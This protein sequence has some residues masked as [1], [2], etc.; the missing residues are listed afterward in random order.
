MNTV[1]S[2]PF[3]SIIIPAWNREDVIERCLNSIFSQEFTDYEVIVVDDGSTDNTVK[4][5]KSYNNQKLNLIRQP[6][7][8]GVCAARNIGTAS[9]LGKWILSL[10]TDWELLPGALQFI[11]SMAQKAPSDVGIVGGHAKSEQ[12]EIW[13]INPMPDMPFGF[14][15]Y[16]KW[17]N[18]PGHTDYLP[19]RRKEIFKTI[20]WPTDRRLEA[21]FHL[22]VAKK[23]KR[24]V[25]HKVLA[26]AYTNCPNSITRDKSF[27]GV[28][29]L[30]E[31][32]P[33]LSIDYDEIVEN[34]GN[35]LKQFAPELFWK[36]CMQ[37]SKY[38]FL[39]GEKLLGLKFGLRAFGQKPF[40]FRPILNIL[41]GLG[42]RKFMVWTIRNRNMFK[43]F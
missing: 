24:W 27:Q 22:K 42:G 31:M 32:A 13:P 3:I 2:T 38:K 34:F 14:I 23:W 36:Y 21:Q 20:Q 29:R 9:A 5:L 12:G 8:K 30:L 26:I 11:A 33:D 16:L 40:N 25:S 18:L 6:R 19:C 43:R 35:D 4:I 1:K 10:D 15:E 7:N 41:R 28:N 17:I 37:A 39:T